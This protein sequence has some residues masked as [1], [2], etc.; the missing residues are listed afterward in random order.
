[1]YLLKAGTNFPPTDFVPCNVATIYFI[2]VFF[3]QS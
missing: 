2:P 1:M 3:E